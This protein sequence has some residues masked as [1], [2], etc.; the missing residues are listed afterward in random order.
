MNIKGI[1]GMCQAGCAIVASVED[2]RLVGV[3]PDRESAFGRVCPRGALA[4]KLIHSD[5][6]LTAPLI[7][8]GERGEGRFRTATWDEAL[9]KV[10]EL[11]SDVI[12]RH[13]GK[14]LASYFG[15]G[16]LGEPLTRFHGVPDA[17]LTHLG[18]PNDLNCSCICFQSA[19]VVAPLLTMGF[20]CASMMPDLDNSERIFVWGRN[21]VTDDGPQVM[22][23]RIRNAKKRGAEVIVIDPR[24]KGIAEE[25]DLWI[26][27][28]PGSD[29]A[30]ALAMLKVILNSGRY[31]KDFVE[32]HVRG[33]D[34]YVQYLE[35]QSVADL[36]RICHITEDTL[37]QLVDRFCATEKC[38]FLA[39]T[40]LEYH[41]S[42]TQNYRMLF[43]LWALTGKLDVPGG[44]LITGESM[45]EYIYTAKKDIMPVGSETYPMFY[46]ILGTGQFTMLPRA[47]LEGVPYP[48]RGLIVIGGSPASSFPGGKLWQDVY[49][50]L[51]SLVVL[52]RYMTEEC[53]YADV[54]LPSASLFE[55]ECVLK[56]PNGIRL[57]R[58]LIPPVGESRY[59]VFILADIA[60][61]FG[62]GDIY[63]HDSDE[64]VL[65]QLDGDREKAA[66]LR[67]HGFIA[68]PKREQRY[69]K[70][71]SGLLR[72]DGSPGF[73]TPSGK[74]E[75]S[76]SVAEEFGYVAYPEFLDMSLYSDVCGSVCGDEFPLMLTSGARSM[77]RTGSFGA[78]MP[79]MSA[80]EPAPYAEISSATAS[81]CGVSDGD[82]VQLSTAFGSRRFVAKTL[83]MA[84][85][86][87]HIPH[88]GG[89]SFMPDLWRD[90]NV[91]ALCSLDV[92][93]KITGFPV[94]KSL[95][96]RIERVAGV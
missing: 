19:N 79:E 56:S 21:P 14:A 92:A 22:I 86:A 37:L 68:A 96:C 59:D 60:D 65:W 30:L 35:S 26:P 9:A 87:V 54:I 93:D 13:G 78:N 94:I 43:L 53:L 10:H 6:R 70:Y 80:I 40:G 49:S 71:D 63:P 46:H 77:L 41:P 75:I 81:S 20:T 51:D 17:F 48:V 57:R 89:S 52:D 12:E 83:P 85:G 95:P 11:W 38:S 47:V 45:P 24:G 50:Q 62:F 1:C 67:E 18:S 88:G 66:M 64:L 91:N 2:G 4:P 55:T 33:F 82:V 73:P 74:F 28:Y 29:G 42:G 31:D 8:T 90:G 76:S 23:G 32:R 15:R 27:I 7:R 58:Q 5:K 72:E 3:A 16:V 34:E 44:Q 84:D 25:A 61:R 36:C 39:Y 69:K